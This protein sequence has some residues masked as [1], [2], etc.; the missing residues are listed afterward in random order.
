[1]SRWSEGLPKALG[2][3]FPT[4]ATVTLRLS[5]FLVLVVLGQAPSPV[6]RDVLVAAVGTLAAFTIVTESGAA[7]YMLS[8]QS[9]QPGRGEYRIALGLQLGLG[10]LGGAMALALSAT[11]SGDSIS[12]V[13]WLVLGAI[14]LSQVVDGLLRAA[15]APLLRDSRDAAYA[16]PEFILALA[17]IGTIAVALVLRELEPLLVL[18]LF[19]VAVAAWTIWSVRRHLHDER[20]RTSHVVRAI[21]PFGLTGSISSLYSQLPVIVSA[22][23]LPVSATAMLTVACRVVQPLEILPGTAS[24]QLLPRVRGLRHRLLRWWLAFVAVGAVLAASAIVVAPYIEELLNVT[25]WSWAVFLLVAAA[26][27]PKSGNYLL[28]AAVMALGGINRRLVVTCAVAALSVLACLLTVGPLGSTGLAA[29]MVGS[30]VLLAVGLGVALHRTRRD[31]R[32]TAG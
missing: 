14:A 29:V 25:A 17:K 4:V 19:S 11:R 5:Q 9:G 15:R 6:V 24:L 28:A 7:N 20:V 12:P 32:G 27:V 23:V 1:M 26:L 21:V 31:P 18:P 13:L 10:L 30:E 8:R 2:L 16:L 22:A 3:A